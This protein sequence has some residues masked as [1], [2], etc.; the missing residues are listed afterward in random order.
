MGENSE[1]RGN[2]VISA[3]SHEPSL[4]CFHQNNIA[5]CRRVDIL[6]CGTLIYKSERWT[7]EKREGKRE[8]LPEG[9]REGR[10]GMR[11]NLRD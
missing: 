7:E 3:L 9:Q 4:S 6:A 8:G 1:Y 10:E 2:T 5:C 11:E